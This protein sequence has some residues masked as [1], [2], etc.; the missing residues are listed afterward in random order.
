M[1]QLIINSEKLK[2]NEQ[3]VLQ[4]ARQGKYKVLQQN[5]PKPNEENN[6]SKPKTNVD[7]LVLSLTKAF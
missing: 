5:K 3:T 2:E 6:A 1:M 4:A 7:F